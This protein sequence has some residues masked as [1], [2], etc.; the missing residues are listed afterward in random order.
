MKGFE[1]IFRIVSSYVESL[2][3]LNNQLKQLR[4]KAKLMFIQVL[5]ETHP[6]LN[7]RKEEILNYMDDDSIL[8]KVGELLIEKAIID[9][10]VCDYVLA[11]QK[12]RYKKLSV[13]NS[14]NGDDIM[15]NPFQ[16]N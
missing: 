16:L 8:T 6:A 14:I 15:T 7:S 11:E 4:K 2:D 10:E 5:F 9:S 12:E 13:K 1:E 3:D